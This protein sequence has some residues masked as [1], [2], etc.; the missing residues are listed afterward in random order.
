MGEVIKINNLSF[1]YDDEKDYVL[2]NLNLKVEKGEWISIV[3]HNGSGK[4][5]LAKFFN[6]LL[7]PSTKG[8]VIV[9]G[10]DL[11][12]QE[13][14]WEVRKKVG[15]IFQNPDNQIV[16]TTVKDDIAF[17]LENIGV[18][19]QEIVRRIDESLKK[20]KMEAYLDYEPHRL[21]GGQKQRVA[22][23]G[24]VA[25]RP[26]VM[27][28][29]EA[30]SMLDP[31]GRKEV[32]NTIIEL[33]K[34]EN[35]TVINITHDLDEVVYSDRVIVMNKGEI[36]IEGAPKKIFS[37]KTKLLE[38]G[39]HLPFSLQIQERLKEEG[40]MLN[41]ICLTK[42]ELVAELWKLNSKT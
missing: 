7:L 25:M 33:K 28:L 34:Q 20:V 38:A 3:G 15:M 16:A 32:L 5:T 29:D 39:L 4:S 2:K 40:F 17:G 37:E 23:A 27:V 42:E 18:E 14:V 30:T 35:I 26:A 1:K 13:M 36:S 41:S 19:R 24:I 31:V 8:Q 10:F 22:I 9:H 11:S 6:G 21:S 12:E